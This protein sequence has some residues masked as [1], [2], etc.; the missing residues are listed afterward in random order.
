M[1]Q[2]MEKISSCIRMTLEGK[3]TTLSA[4]FHGLDCKQMIRCTDH[5]LNH[6]G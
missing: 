3:A 2:M 1:F 5:R 6:V 4:H